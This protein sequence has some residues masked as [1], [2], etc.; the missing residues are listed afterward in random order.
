MKMLDNDPDIKTKCSTAQATIK[1]SSCVSAYDD[2]TSVD[3]LIIYH[4]SWYK[5]EKSVTWILKIRSELFHR[6][7]QK[8]LMKGED[9]LIFS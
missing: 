6:V 1:N 8:K 4:S 3:K 5:L 7:R 2:H 9:Q